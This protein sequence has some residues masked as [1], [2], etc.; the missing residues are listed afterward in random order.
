MTDLISPSSFKMPVTVAWSNLYCRMTPQPCKLAS[1][2][3]DNNASNEIAGLWSTILG[4]LLPG[5]VVASSWAR[6]V[7]VVVVVVALGLELL[8]GCNCWLWFCLWRLP[9][10]KAA[11]EQHSMR[12]TRAITTSSTDKDDGADDDDDGERKR[13]RNCLAIIFNQEMNG[14]RADQISVEKIGWYRWLWS[15]F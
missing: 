7:M 1:I 5:S 8:V 14:Q 9:G 12:M 10:T 6:V 15:C 2:H 4:F 11:V 13:R 3:D